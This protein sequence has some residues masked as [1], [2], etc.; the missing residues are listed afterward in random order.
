MEFQQ[1]VNLA[2]G[3]RCKKN[4]KNRDDA[5][6]IIMSRGDP[7]GSKSATWRIQ[8]WGKVL[9][10]SKWISI[11]CNVIILSDFLMCCY[12]QTN[13]KNIILSHRYITEKDF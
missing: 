6:T 5:Y 10:G 9:L 12:A 7:M 2:S 11:I 13:P 1:C 3:L 4:V 8:M